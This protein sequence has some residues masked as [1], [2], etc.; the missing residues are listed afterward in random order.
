MWLLINYAKIDQTSL[1][2]FKDELV[3]SW[4][5]AVASQHCRVNKL[6]LGGK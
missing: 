2:V 5:K 1:D 4:L 6:T 3:V